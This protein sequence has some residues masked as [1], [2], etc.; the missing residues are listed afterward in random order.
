[1]MY[2]IGNMVGSQIFKSQDAPTYTP[3]VIGCCICFGLELLIIAGM[4]LLV[5]DAD[6]KRL[7]IS[8][9]PAWRTILVL[10]N[11]RRD[12][13][14]ATD[15]LTNEERER[16]GKINGEKDLTDFENPYV[17]PIVFKSK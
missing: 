16:L 2:C 13:A 9:L 1:M 4:S 15:G 10:R 14:Q 8:R 17:S 7:I 6:G 5:I 3:G 11:R 12:C